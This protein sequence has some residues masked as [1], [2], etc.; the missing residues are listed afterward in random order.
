MEHIILRK[1][2]ISKTQKIQ[3]LIRDYLNYDVVT[4]IAPKLDEG[5]LFELFN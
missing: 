2:E 3:F 4:R 1:Y 5:W